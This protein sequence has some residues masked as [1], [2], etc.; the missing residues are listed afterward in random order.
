MKNVLYN[1]V[2]LV[3]HFESRIW[4][5]IIYANVLYDSYCIK[6]PIVCIDILE[7]K[8]VCYIVALKMQ[9]DELFS[10][11]QFLQSLYLDP[12]YFFKLELEFLKTID[13]STN[14]SSTQIKQHPYYVTLCNINTGHSRFNYI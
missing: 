13:Y 3:E 12:V 10:V 2:R 8:L 11:K 4:L 9:Y 5:F 7:C 14:V 6:N 1:F